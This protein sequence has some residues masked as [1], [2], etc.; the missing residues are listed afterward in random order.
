MKYFFRATLPHVTW[1]EPDSIHQ[2]APQLVSFANGRS[3]NLMVR[4]QDQVARMRWHRHFALLLL[5]GTGSAL[6]LAFP[7]LMRNLPVLGTGIALFFSQLCHQDPTRSFVLAGTTLPVCARCLAFYLGGFAGI[8]SYP[9][10]GSRWHQG[11]NLKRPL[12]VSLCLIVLDVGLDLAG[13]RENTFFSRSIT[14]AVFGGVLRLARVFCLQQSSGFHSSSE[15]WTLTSYQHSLIEVTSPY[16]FA[17]STRPVAH[18]FQ[19][20]VK[21]N[22]SMLSARSCAGFRGVLLSEHGTRR[23]L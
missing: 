18:R 23:A 11:L 17:N 15:R 14:G 16:L 9:V 2:V 10:L 7:W 22:L 4:T 13:I 12:I 20:L 1:M 8:A 6:L 3:E 19:H 5:A 21:P